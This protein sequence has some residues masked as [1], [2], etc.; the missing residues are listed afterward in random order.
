MKENQLS[1]WGAIA[2]HIPLMNPSAKVF[3]LA[4]ASAD[5]YGELA[6]EFTADRDGV[7]RVH[8]TFAGVTGNGGLVASRGDVVLVMPGYTETL[9]GTLTLSS[10]GVRWI[11]IGEGTL[12]PTIT[13]NAAVDG[14]AISGANVEFENFRFAAPTTDA[15]LSMLRVKAA[16][17]KLKNITGIGSD[18]TNNFVDCIRVEAASNDLVLED[19]RL[20]TGEVAVTSFLN[21][22]GAISRCT[23]GGFFAFGSVATAGVID[24]TSCRII[25]ANFDRMR[26]VVGGSAKPAIT[27]DAGGR[28]RGVVTNSY[29]AGTH[30]TLATNASFAGDW[31]L[32]QVYVSEETNNAA[33]GALI[34]AVDSD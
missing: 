13:V 3:I 32:S 25:G 18:Q 24:G 16:G 27:L 26:V 28:S 30:T 20:W 2:K 6:Q 7:N 34:P 4:P 11:G 8:S 14:V 9:T 31:R 33:Q 21:F 15:A 10:A 22:N 23:I 12:K 19:I 17:V 29:F 5:Y 1:R